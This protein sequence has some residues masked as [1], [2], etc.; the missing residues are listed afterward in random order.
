MPRSAA[1]AQ[2][3]LR[4]Y[5]P[6]PPLATIASQVGHGF[7]LTG[8]SCAQAFDGGTENIKVIGV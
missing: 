2:A 7:A 8:A 1:K 5:P 3:V 4:S 6:N